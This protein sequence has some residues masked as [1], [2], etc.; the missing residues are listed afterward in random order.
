MLKMISLLSGDGGSVPDVRLY[1]LIFLKF[2]QSIIPNIEYDYTS[3]F[4]ISHDVSGPVWH[5]PMCIQQCA[6]PLP[7]PRPV[8]PQCRARA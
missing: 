7:Y 8:Q 2:I 3:Q 6:R 1:L 4:E 5:R